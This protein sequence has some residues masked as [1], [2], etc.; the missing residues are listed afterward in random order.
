MSSWVV[1]KGVTGGGRGGEG[2]DERAN[3]VGLVE[4]SLADEVGFVDKANDGGGT[5]VVVTSRLK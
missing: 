5:S 2:D 1:V 3:L 4:R